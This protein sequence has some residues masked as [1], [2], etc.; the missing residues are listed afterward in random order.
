MNTSLV[1]SLKPGHHISREDAFRALQ[2]WL[3]LHIV[4]MIARNDIS[5]EILETY[6]HVDSYKITLNHS[7]KQV[8]RL[9]LL[10]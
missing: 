9:L 7:R 1:A 2:V 10:Y 3:D 4:T 6:I 8:P 5:Q